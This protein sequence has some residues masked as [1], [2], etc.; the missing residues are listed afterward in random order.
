MSPHALPGPALFLF[1]VGLACCGGSTSTSGDGGKPA[2]DAS[3]DSS[4]DA[5]GV[6]LAG[7][8]TGRPS[9]VQCSPSNV[10]M[11]SGSDGGAIACTT[12]ADCANAGLYHWCRAGAC[13]P[14]Q[15]F[16]DSDCP[17]GQACA[18]N[19]QQV[20]NAVHTNACV[21]TQCRLD[22]DCGS[23]QVCSP[24]VQDLCSG[25]GPFFACH[26]SAD[27]CRV[28][29]DCCT[30]APSCRYQSTVGHWACV[31]FCTVSG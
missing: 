4:P 20:G 13:V 23:G 2:T 12:D 6:N 15:C 16:I 7:T 3:A 1:I 14:D 24:T 30:G 10:P 28:D 17:T 11:P 25:G 22:S 5:C 31:A 21:M 19:D 8:P 18:C 29:A 9:A 26:S 27:T